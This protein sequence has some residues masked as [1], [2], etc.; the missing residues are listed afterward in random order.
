M[1]SPHIT[2]CA[3]SLLIKTLR[4]YSALCTLQSVPVPP[5]H[6][7]KSAPNHSSDDFLI[8]KPVFY[9][10]RRLPQSIFCA[11]LCDGSQNFTAQ[12]PS[13]S[14]NSCLPKPHQ[15]SASAPSLIK[16]PSSV[17]WDRLW[18]ATRR[19]IVVN[20]KVRQFF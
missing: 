17:P 20:G 8:T 10:F 7:S 9:V 18:Q 14:T 11:I 2:G 5:T 15:T 1:L 12:R 4:I 13:T 6:Y 16:T 19:L 3:G